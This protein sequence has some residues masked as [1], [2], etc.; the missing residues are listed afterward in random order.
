MELK[1]RNKLIGLKINNKNK[2]DYKRS[3]IAP[4]VNDGDI[5]KTLIRDDT[6][7]STYVNDITFDVDTNFIEDNKLIAYYRDI[8]KYPIVDQAIEI[9]CNETVNTTTKKQLKLNVDDTNFSAE[10]KRKIIEE[11]DEILRLYNFRYNGHD[12]FKDWYIDGRLFYEIIIDPNNL[13]KGI[14]EL[15]PINPFYIRKIYFIN[16]ITDD[17]NNFMYED[18][19]E[20]YIYSEKT[21]NLP[22]SGGRFRDLNNYLNN[23]DFIVFEKDSIVYSNSGVYDR[24]NGVILSHLNKSIRIINQLKMMEDALVIY[25][26]ARAPERRVVYVDVDGIQPSKHDQTVRNFAINFKQDVMYDSASGTVKSKNLFN[27]LMEDYFLPR[28][29]GKNTEI[30]TLEGGKSLGEVEDVEYFERKSFQ[31]LNVPVSRLQPDTGFTIGKTSEITR[32]EV[33][34]NKF[35]ERL[36]LKFVPVFL[37]PLRVQLIAKGIITPEEWDENEYYFDIIFPSDVNFNKLVELD[38]IQSKL[39]ILS[40]IH[41]YVGKDGYY[42]KEYVRREILDLSDEEIAQIKKEIAEEDEDRYEDIENA[43]SSIFD[44]SEMLDV[45]GDDEDLDNQD[46]DEKENI[47]KEDDNEN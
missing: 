18:V 35:I 8:S 27:S 15:R 30:V 13:K 3:Y 47:N 11:F 26:V 16:T 17:R 2:Y 22:N 10:V 29:R 41:S 12:A 37:Q 25:R 14:Q 33:T 32:E 1:F 38:I 4:N 45:R 6:A 36:R 44:A 43:V 21:S 24:S 40:S 20:Y 31:S 42:S 46:T 19:Q 23:P 7:S 9:I 28:Y 34:F 5:S 39:D